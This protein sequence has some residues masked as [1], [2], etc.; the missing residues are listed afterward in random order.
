MSDGNGHVLT[1]RHRAP[2]TDPDAWDG[3][4]ARMLTRYTSLRVDY[5]AGRTIDADRMAGVADGLEQ[6]MN[7]HNRER[8]PRL[9]APIVGVKAVRNPDGT[10][11]VRP[12]YGKP[13]R[14]P[15]SPWLRREWD[16][17]R[18]Q[19]EEN[20][21]RGYAIRM[22]GDDPLTPMDGRRSRTGTGDGRR[23]RP[24]PTPPP[25][26]VPTPPPSPPQRHRRAATPED[27]E[28][29]NRIPGVHKAWT[30]K[31]IDE[32]DV[33]VVSYETGRRALGCWERPGVFSL[34]VLNPGANAAGTHAVLKADVRHCADERAKRQAL[35]DLVRRGFDI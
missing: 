33:L 19:E 26:P 10:L 23:M 6:H 5:D 14:R 1:V 30:D 17:M 13:P 28:R 34:A 8:D 15:W 35:D 25:M 3:S 29:F 21:T 20:H 9:E 24:V 27:V 16:E 2:S 31:G 22:P 7:R 11:T 32:D 18:A 4:S 12:S